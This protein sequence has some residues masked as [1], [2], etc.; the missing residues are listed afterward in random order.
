MGAKRLTEEGFPCIGLPGTIDNDVVG[1]RLHYRLLHPR[2]KPWWKRSNRLRDTSSSHQR[3]SIVEVM[4]RYCG[5]LT[6]AAAIAGGC[7]FIDAAWKSNSI[8][9]RSGGAKSRPVSPGVKTRH[10]GD[11]R[12]SATSMSW[13][14][15]SSRKP[16]VKPAPPCWGHIQRVVVHRSPTTASWPRAWRLRHRTAAAGLRRPLRRYPERK[17]WCITTSSTRSKT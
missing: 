7:E 2:W 3:I 14:A 11:H 8:A 9:R 5:D 12:A 4:G 16:S 6:L 13:R 15:T 17:K 10:R 1:Y